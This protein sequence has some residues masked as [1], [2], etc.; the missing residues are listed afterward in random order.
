[1]KRLLAVTPI[2]PVARQSGPRKRS[3]FDYAKAVFAASYALVM[4]PL[5]A[6]LFQ[7]WQAQAERN[8]QEYRIELDGI[9]GF[10]AK[11]DET[12]NLY[13]TLRYAEAQLFNPEKNHLLTRE[14]VLAQKK[15]VTDLIMKSGSWDGDLA[16]VRGTYFDDPKVNQSLDKLLNEVNKLKFR[17]PKRKRSDVQ[18]IQQ[19]MEIYMNEAILAMTSSTVGKSRKRGIAFF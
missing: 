3:R 1:M 5:L 7:S 12:L 19:H 15:A 17:D 8:R 18:L 2:M 13:L 4:P 16:Y 14:E 10:S 6:Y 11:A 9:K